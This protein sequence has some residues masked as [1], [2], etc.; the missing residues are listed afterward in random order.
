M[1]YDVVILATYIQLPGAVSYNF[2]ELDS[3]TI[4]DDIAARDQILCL[5][6]IER[7]AF[8]Y[9]DAVLDDRLDVALTF[10]RCVKVDGPSF[11]FVHE[12]MLL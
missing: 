3:T 9:L 1:H 5:S 11:F 2:T 4:Q 12:Q 10:V 8:S 7:L 6:A